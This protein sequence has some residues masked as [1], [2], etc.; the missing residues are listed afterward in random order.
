MPR[1]LNSQFTLS[2]GLCDAEIFAEISRNLLRRKNILLPYLRNHA[3]HFTHRELMRILHGQKPVS[4]STFR[5]LSA[6]EPLE[7][8]PADYSSVYFRM[9]VS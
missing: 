2:D 4:L 5:Y 3:P 1:Y 8:C 9:A 7:I 6:G